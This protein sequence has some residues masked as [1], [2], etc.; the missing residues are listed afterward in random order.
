MRTGSI[1]CGRPPP[2]CALPRS[3]RLR[4]LQRLL[5]AIVLPGVL[6][7][8]GSLTL[9]LVAAVSGLSRLMTLALPMPLLA[10]LGTVRVLAMPV[11][12]AMALATVTA[13]IRSPPITAMRMP[14]RLSAL[15][16][17]VW[18]MPVRSPVAPF[19]SSIRLPRV[20]TV[21]M[22]AVRV[23]GAVLAMAAPARS[24]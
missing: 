9:S 23:T 8:L 24:G 13:G 20:A 19:R 5:S 15:R 16:F 17:G 1:R 22:L 2:E 18:A 11:R 6:L 14:A 10:R 3:P 4:A 7:A 12:S 21:R